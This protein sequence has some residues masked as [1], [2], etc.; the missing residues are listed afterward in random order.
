MCGQEIDKTKPW[1]P[2]NA[3]YGVLKI[4]NHV[5]TEYIVAKTPLSNHKIDNWIQF[6]KNVNKNA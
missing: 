5:K 3:Y 6:Q 1:Q 4:S 2:L